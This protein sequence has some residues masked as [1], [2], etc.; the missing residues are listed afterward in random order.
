MYACGQSRC[1]VI[2]TQIQLTDD[3]A[4]SLK[5]LSA[6]TGV[7]IAELVR[8]GLA[9]LLR[10]Q[11]TEHEE[12]ARRAAAVIGRFHSGKTD[13]SADHDRYLADSSRE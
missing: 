12:R 9:P 2:R 7:S 10:N 13:I 3:Q 11:S 8:R 1:Q 5:A 6:K 4:Q